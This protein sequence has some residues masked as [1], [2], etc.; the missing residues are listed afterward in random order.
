[1]WYHRKPCMIFLQ[2]YQHEQAQS[3]SSIWS[4]TSC[5]S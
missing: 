3:S 5:T 1:M 4:P 2:T